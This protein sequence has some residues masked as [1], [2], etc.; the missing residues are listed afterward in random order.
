MSEDRYVSD[1]TA[2]DCLCTELRQHRWIAVDTEFVRERTYFPNLCLVQVAVPQMVACVDPIALG[3][4]EPLLD[5]LYD[6]SIVKVLHAAAQD[7]EIFYGLRQAP[8]E[9]I[10]DTQ[11]AAAVLG[12][13]D[14]VGYGT[15]VKNLLGVDLEKGH[16][17]TDWTRRPLDAEQLRYAADD[18]RYLRELY[19]LQRNE[20][21]Q[22]GR[23]RWL[24]EDFSSLCDPERYRVNPEAAWKRVKGTRVLRAADMPFLQQLAAWREREA[25]ANNLPRRWVLG[26]EALVELARR[27]P[28]Q[29][30]VLDRMRGLN[31]GQVRR[32]GKALLQVVAEA[33]A[34]P[35]EDWPPAPRQR[36]LSTEQ[37]A[38]TDAA[39]AVIRAQAARNEVSAASLASR[40]ELE[41]MVLGERELPLLQG[42]RAEIAGRAVLSLVE[43]RTGLM[44][45]D[46]RLEMTA[47]RPPQ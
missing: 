36:R 11:I 41:R 39:S 1:A 38:V 4:I 24:D 40:A 2:L 18:V 8:P 28:S 33:A 29:S 16:A 44:V 25:A 3:D 47:D 9:P 30:A 27:K 6:Y 42:W 19:Q 46:G 15:L 17:R 23:L 10:F 22:R 43:G 20:L 7:M 35:Q 31:E 12:Q 32:Y 5:V 45:Q 26:D 37:E 21:G 34:V 14:Q 13:G